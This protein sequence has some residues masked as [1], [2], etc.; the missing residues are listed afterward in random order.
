M[1]RVLVLGQAGAGKSHFA[2]ALGAITGLPVFHMDKVHWQPG[3]QERDR[4]EKSRL[5]HEI[6][7]GDEWILEGGL[8]ATCPEPMARADTA[9]WL[10]LPLGVRARRILGRRWQYRGGWTRPDLP[11]NCPERLHP[12]FLQFIWR[13]RHSAREKVAQAL[14]DAPH[15]DVH[16]ILSAKG[17]NTLLDWIRDDHQ[18]ND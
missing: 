16:H 3:W 17:A 8:S 14:A 4:A 10:D 13:T 6:M 2:V 18:N 1:K 7:S 5:V 12:A 11:D 15:L 9:I